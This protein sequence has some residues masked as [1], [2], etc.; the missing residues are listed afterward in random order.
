MKKSAF[1][2][3]VLAASAG[4]AL[5]QPVINGYAVNERIF[6]DDPGS[7]VNSVVNFPTSVTISD[8]NFTGGG[9][10][11]RHNWRLSDDG[12]AT[13][14]DF[15][16]GD[17]FSLMT[18][19]TISGTGEAEAGLN[20]SPWWSQNVDGVFNLRTTDGEVAI[21]GG[22][23]PFYSFTGDQGVTYT[24]GSTVSIGLIYSANSNTAGDPA[25]IEY[26]YNDGTA[27]TSGALA[28]D[29]GNPAEGFGSWGMLDNAQAGGFMQVFLGSGGDISTTWDNINYVPT[30]AS[31]ALLGLGG[32]VATR[33]R[34]S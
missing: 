14:A 25:T 7:T 30:P 22:R 11:N 34:R 15:S 28:F 9:F 32:L 5:A 4:S 6:N 26:L 23:L 20:L 19:I 21:F 24:K 17:S 8:G 27:Y 13:G 2:V 31:A 10:A 16:N 18:D 29:E 1:A 3:I 12:G 33:R